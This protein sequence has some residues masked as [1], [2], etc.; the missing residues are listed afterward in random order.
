[1]I[2]TI[3]YQKMFDA[4]DKIMKYSDQMSNEE[5]SKISK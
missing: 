1:M 4:A 3:E 5:K 2:G